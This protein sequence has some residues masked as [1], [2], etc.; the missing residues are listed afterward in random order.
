MKNNCL[1]VK[2]NSSGSRISNFKTK[3]LK[4]SNSGFISGPS[5]AL[6]S[7]ARFYWRPKIVVGHKWRGTCSHC[8]NFGHS[9]FN[10]HQVAR[11]D[12][13]SFL[14]KF[15]IYQSTFISAILV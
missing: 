9:N 10:C 1:T 4:A 6:G 8:K 14:N 3:A 2:A 11:E 13:E 15:K 5:M 7:K 12:F